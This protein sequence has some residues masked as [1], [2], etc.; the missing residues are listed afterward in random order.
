MAARLS[1][2]TTPPTHFING[3]PTSR[4]SAAPSTATRGT[5]DLP[6]HFTIHDEIYT[7]KNWSRDKTHVLLRLDNGTVDLAKG[8]RDDN[9]F[10]MAWCHPFGQGRVFYTALGHAEPTWD[11]D[12]FHKHLLGGIQWAMGDAE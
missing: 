7:H 8:N 11:S 4:W 3:R 9:D 12:L 6:E 10:A 2:S 1:A 5:R